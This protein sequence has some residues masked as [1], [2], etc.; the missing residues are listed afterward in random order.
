M[1]GARV[2]VAN[3]SVLEG[4]LDSDIGYRDFKHLR[5]SPDYWEWPEHSEH[6]LFGCVQPI[7]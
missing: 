3:A 5:G 7:T 1:R 6:V 4:L 2:Q